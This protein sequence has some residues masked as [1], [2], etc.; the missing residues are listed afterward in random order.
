MSG[1]SQDDA[2]EAEVTRE[3]VRR[4]VAVTSYN[5]AR[6][7]HPRCLEIVDT[8]HGFTVLFTTPNDQIGEVEHRFRVEPLAEALLR[9]CEFGVA[10]NW[11]SHF[12]S[13]LPFGLTNGV[14]D[15]IDATRVA[16]MEFDDLRQEGSG[17]NPQAR[18]EA[19][20][21]MRRR[22]ETLVEPPKS[23]PEKEVTIGRIA[24]AVA[25]LLHEGQSATN[26]NHKLISRKIGCSRRAVYKALTD[27]GQKLDE[28]VTFFARSSPPI[29]QK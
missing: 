29:V 28:L 4:L 3:Q 11:L 7:A 27:E 21:R 19:L 13:T 12:L 17:R 26:I 8:P 20:D 23:G 24:I 2:Q 5:Y 14:Q 15:T 18:R 16:H 25:A 10:Y 9:T 1:D 22:N 6:Y